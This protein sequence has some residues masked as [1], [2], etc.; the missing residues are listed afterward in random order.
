MLGCSDVWKI[1]LGD[2]GR[3]GGR[4]TRGCGSWSL[5]LSGVSIFAIRCPL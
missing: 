2:E 1:W 4:E 5:D 3:E